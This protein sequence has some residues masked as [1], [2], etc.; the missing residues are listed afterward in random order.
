MSTKLYTVYER[1]NRVK[2]PDTKTKVDVNTPHGAALLGS[3][4]RLSGRATDPEDI[5]NTMQLMEALDVHDGSTTGQ[6]VI[7]NRTITE[8]TDTNGV[9]HEL[10]D[11]ATIKVYCVNGMTI[12]GTRSVDIVG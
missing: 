4:V 6:V 12:T 1:T 5:V 3:V 7:G 8:L 2:L 10:D 11:P 9:V